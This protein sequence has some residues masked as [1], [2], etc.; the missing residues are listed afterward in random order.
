MVSTLAKIS[1]KNLLIFS[2]YS[3]SRT[4]TYCHV[5]YVLNCHSLFNYQCCITT[6]EVRLSC[7]FR[8]FEERS[9]K[10]SSWL[11]H[12]FLSSHLIS[13]LVRVIGEN[14]ID[15]NLIWCC[16][17]AMKIEENVRLHSKFG[18]IKLQEIFNGNFS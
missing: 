7:S 6:W 9:Q 14:L 5:Q 16:Q 13:F 8:T 4:Y 12:L 15:A 11:S 10:L 17:M 3:T 18:G 1:V 2:I